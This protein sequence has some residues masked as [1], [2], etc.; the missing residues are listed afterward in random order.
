M[1]PLDPALHDLHESIAYCWSPSLLVTVARMVGYHCGH[2]KLVLEVHMPQ[3]NSTRGRR[4][5]GELMLQ[6]IVA[7]PSGPWT[8]RDGPV[9]ADDPTSGRLTH[10]CDKY[11]ASTGDKRG[12]TGIVR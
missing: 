3:V 7:W 10:P 2:Q 11:S 4:G 8:V 12:M 6:L 5:E 9:G 1:G